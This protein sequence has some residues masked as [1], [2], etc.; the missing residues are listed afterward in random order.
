SPGSGIIKDIKYGPRRVIEKIEIELDKDQQ[1]LDFKSHSMDDISNLSGDEVLD[2]ILGANL[3]PHFRQRPFNTIPDHEIKPRDIFIS[4]LNTAPLAVDLE[5]VITD[6]IENF[7]AGINAIEKLTDGNVYLTNKVDSRLSG[8]ENV[9]INTI[10]GPHPSGNVGIQIHHISHLKPSELIWTI[11]P[12]DVVMLGKLFLKGVY[13]PSKIISVAGPGVKN[14]IH[15]R[16][17]TGYPI[18]SILR[19]NLSSED[20]RLISGDVL[21]GRECTLEDYIGFY[22]SSISV[23]SNEINREFIGMLNPGSSSSR[24][25]LTPVF[26]SLSNILFPFTSSQNGNH[27]AVVPINSWERVLPMD[28]LPNELYRSIL[29]ED[30]EEM[31]SLGL[32]EC[33]DEDFA[34]CSFACPSKTDVSGVIRKGLDMLQAEV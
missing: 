29:A 9:N 6:Q 30:I 27:R 16:V 11:D 3:F 22:D 25:S 28:I 21:T 2:V 32:F 4:G 26:V 5:I 15:L 1:S 8:V 23:I 14:P 31:E 12:Q 34:L 24:Y 13:D 33:D 18:E 7:Q 20:V 17:K 10:E 19:S